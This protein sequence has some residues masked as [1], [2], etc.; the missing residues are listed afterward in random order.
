MAPPL[1]Y[2]ILGAGSQGAAAAYDLLRFDD[3]A[4]VALA[5]ADPALARNTAKKLARL[6]PRTERRLKAQGLDARSPTALDRLLRGRKAALS[7]LPY[8]LNPAAAAAAIRACVPYADLG[9]HFDTT[10]EIQK[11]DAKARKAGVPLLPDCGI[12]PGTCNV[13]AAAG[14]ARMDR[15]DEVHIYCGGLPETPRPPLGYKLVFNLEG[16]LGNYFGKAYVLRDGEIA[17][18]LPLSRRQ[19]MDFPG[20]GRLEAAVT[21]GATATAPWTWKGKVR[22]YDYKTVRWPGH[23]DKI[24]TLRDL[25][26]LDEAPLPVKGRR[27]SPRDVFVACAGPRLRFPDDRDLLVQRV[28]VTGQK[29]G[30]PARATFD[31]LDR[32]DPAT[33]FTAMQRTTGFSA[34]VILAMLAK[35]RISGAGVLPLETAVPPFEFIEELRR[36]GVAVTESSEGGPA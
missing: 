34:A 19:I 32:F 1:S 13:L 8:Y 28:I 5:D 7:A 10:R 14:I 18:D 35:K 27:V 17:E 2:V 26:L 3:A 4:L 24:E 29:D 21:G 20:V 33:G 6:L 31:L 9:G 16:V 23:W 15:A 12:S 25:G 11:L 36:R 22:S 30:R